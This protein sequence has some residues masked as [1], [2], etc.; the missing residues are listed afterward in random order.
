MKATLEFNLPEEIEEYQDA[1]NGTK[2]KIQIDDVWNKI[3]RP[4]HKHGYKNEE[5]N[6]LLESD[7]AQKLMDL[8]E[9]IYLEINQD[10]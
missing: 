9:E 4:R 7:E 2:Y 10:L 3:F 5:I 8:L 1:M 6:N